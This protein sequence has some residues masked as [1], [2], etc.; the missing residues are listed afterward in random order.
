MYKAIYIAPALLAEVS[1]DGAL[2]TGLH[3][4]VKRI[5]QREWLRAAVRQTLIPA[6]LVVLS[7]TLAGY[8]LQRAIPGRIRWDK[9]GN[10]LC[11]G[12]R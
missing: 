5:E 7:F 10:T 4:R 2:V 9:S 1:I 6:L 3:R 12:D 8:A 11:K